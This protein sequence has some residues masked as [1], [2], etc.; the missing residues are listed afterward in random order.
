MATAD[1]ETTKNYDELLSVVNQSSDEENDESESEKKLKRGQNRK[2]ILKET[3]TTLEKVNSQKIWRR[4]CITN[5]KFGKKHF[6]N[7][8]LTL[9]RGKQCSTGFIHFFPP[10]T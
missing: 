2:Y 3:F 9:K 6:Y 1:T 5:S 8:N 4:S 7:C 10:I